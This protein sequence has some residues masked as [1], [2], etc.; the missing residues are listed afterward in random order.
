MRYVTVEAAL[1]IAVSEATLAVCQLKTADSAAFT[2][3]NVF[4]DVV[5][6]AGHVMLSPEAAARML[7]VYNL[8]K[9]VLVHDRHV[10]ALN[11]QT[12]SKSL[13]FS[14]VSPPGDPSPQQLGNQQEL[15]FAICRVRQNR[16]Q[17][18]AG[19]PPRRNVAVAAP[20]QGS[21]DDEK[22]FLIAHPSITEPFQ[23][24]S[25]GSLLTVGDFLF[26]HSAAAGPGYSGAPLFDSKGR[27]IG[28]HV[29]NPGG[30]NF[31]CRVDK[32]FAAL[33]AQFPKGWR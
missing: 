23:T 33:D 6:T 4:S 27:L 13:F 25:E 2:A 31:A 1:P 29:A 30:V 7:A 18:Y 5:L 21:Q 24:F 3:T 20:P 12:D 8:R 26:T 22:V 19:D 17:A 28:I 32:I 15:D 9:D 11:S 10:F 14:K 16:A